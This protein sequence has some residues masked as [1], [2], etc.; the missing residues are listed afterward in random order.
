MADQLAKANLGGVDRIYS[1]DSDSSEEE[2]PHKDE[3]NGP[4]LF[5]DDMALGESA[6]TLQRKESVKSETG[7]KNNE[8]IKNK[9][10]EAKERNPSLHR[11]VRRRSIKF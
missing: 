11:L 8:T 6:D 1:D 7:S 2:D 5:A 9:P 3:D 4:D 10:K